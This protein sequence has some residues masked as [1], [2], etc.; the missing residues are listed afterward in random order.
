MKLKKFE[1]NQVKSTN[2]TAIRKIKSG[3]KNG[4][5]LSHKQTNGRGRYGRKWISLKGNLFISIFIRVNDQINIRKTTN[6]NCKIVKQSIEKNFK[7]KITIKL[8]ND[9]LINQKKICGILQEIFNFKNE[10]FMIVG[11]GVN[12][13]ASPNIKNHET[14]Y[15]NKYLKNKISKQILFENIKTVYEKNINFFNLCI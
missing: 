12:I 1:Y 4:I 9:I 15:L 7:N 13:V 3:F 14:T 10:T 2:S 11:I 6:F 8:P 5:I